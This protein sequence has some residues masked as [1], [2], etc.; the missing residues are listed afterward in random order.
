MIELE[1]R[2]D[3]AIA[4]KIDQLS[5][6]VSLTVL[7][8]DFLP[9]KLIPAFLLANLMSP[10]LWSWRNEK[11]AANEAGV[12]YSPKNR[13]NQIQRFFH[14]YTFTNL[15]GEPGGDPWGLLSFDE[16]AKRFG[17]EFVD[18]IQKE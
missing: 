2:R 9:Q 10:A 15:P 14:H 5:T 17:T 7:E 6:A 11:Q 8:I 4:D 12:L 18:T 16:E 13:L 1:L 3:H